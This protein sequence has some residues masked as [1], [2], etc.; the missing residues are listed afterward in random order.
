MSH[1]NIENEDMTLVSPFFIFMLL[2]MSLRGILGKV[3]GNE[4]PRMPIDH[5]TPKWL[6]EYAK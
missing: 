6:Q 5:Q 3:L 4:G 1:R 2:N